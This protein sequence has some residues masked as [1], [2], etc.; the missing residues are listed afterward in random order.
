MQSSKSN[1]TVKKTFLGK[2]WVFNCQALAA[3]G[4]PLEGKSEEGECSPL[5]KN[6]D[7]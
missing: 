4:E 7:P 6:Y 5:P 3:T 2:E 1:K